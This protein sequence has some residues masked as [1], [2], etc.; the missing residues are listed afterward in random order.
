MKQARNAG[1]KQLGLALESPQRHPL[2]EETREELIQA[3]AELLLEAHGD[4]PSNLQ[5]QWGG[6]NE[7]EIDA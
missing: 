1:T 6:G 4:D 3:L 7:S 2:T 5:W